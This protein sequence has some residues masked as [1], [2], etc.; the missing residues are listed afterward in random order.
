M[1]RKSSERTLLAQLISAP[2]PGVERSLATHGHFADSL[3]RNPPIPRV[4]KLQLFYTGRSRVERIEI[5]S[6]Q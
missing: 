4:G 1:D 3:P 5:H 2:G 6:L